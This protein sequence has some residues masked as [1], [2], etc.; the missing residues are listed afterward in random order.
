MFSNI[1]YNN[2]SAP[3]IRG[4]VLPQCSHT[5][6]LGVV[7]DDEL[8]FSAHITTVCNKLS[9]NIGFINKLPHF[10]PKKHCTS[11]ITVLS[12]LI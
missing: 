2:S 1:Y 8:T 4:Q 5:N 10:I 3:Q 11:F 7:I 6:F 9:C 12:F